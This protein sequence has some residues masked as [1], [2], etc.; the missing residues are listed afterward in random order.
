M[1]H[2][3]ARTICFVVL[4][5]YLCPKQKEESLWEA[6]WKDCSG[7]WSLS[8]NRK[9]RNVMFPNDFVMDLLSRSRSLEVISL[10]Y[11]RERVRKIYE[12]ALKR[13]EC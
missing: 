11:L 3:F 12:E 13:N 9:G 10:L 8:T 1:Y 6:D 4:P 7:C 5:P 2:F